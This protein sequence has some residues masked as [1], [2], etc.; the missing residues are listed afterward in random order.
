[1]AE[2]HCEKGG[3][4]TVLVIGNT[5]VDEFYVVSSLPRLGESVLGTRRLRDVG[6]KGANVATVLSR[7]AVPTRFLAVVGDDERG[8]FVQT[9]LSSELFA[10]ELVVS[11]TQPTDVSLVYSDEQ[12]DNTIVTTVDAA[13]SLDQSRAK[14]SL[15]QLQRGDVLILQANLSEALTHFIVNY[16]KALGLTI[17]FNPSPYVAWTR[18]VIR[19]V[20]T[21][22]VNEEE[23]YAL[24]D[25]RDEQSAVAILE[26]GPGSVVITRGDK[27]TLLGRRTT[28]DDGSVTT[29]VIT[30][31]AARVAVVDTTGAGDTFLAVAVA[32]A[33]ARAGAVDKAALIHASRAA[34]ITISAHGTR[35]AFPV[36]AELANILLS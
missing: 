7:C 34:A 6:G 35:S 16:A 20:D 10:L 3:L 26:R 11:K 18:D 9:E 36:K 24:T 29:D 15:D 14:R 33:C 12:G 25:T 21:V 28:T 2:S 13:H 1:M 23:S 4:A 27:G 22:F 19:H 5:A 31:P 17:V 8:S 30:V 32:S